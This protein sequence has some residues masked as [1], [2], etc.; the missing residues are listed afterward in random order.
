MASSILRGGPFAAYGGGLALRTAVRE[1]EEL[2][3][4]F[5]LPRGLY[6]IDVITYCKH[7]SGKLIT[8]QAQDTFSY[9]M[10]MP[11]PVDTGNIV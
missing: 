4:T 11:L 1:E 3:L 8:Q 10:K 2:T 9:T 5:N 7:V 6:I